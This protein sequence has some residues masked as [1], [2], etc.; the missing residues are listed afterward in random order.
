MKKLAFIALTAL[1]IVSC[2]D[3]NAEAMQAQQQKSIDSLKVV[4]EQ[5]KAEEAKQRT[6]DSMRTV[7]QSRTK[8]V[9]ANGS[10]G[11]TTTTTTERKGWSGAAKGAVIGAGAGAIGG[12]LIDKK[13]SGRGAIIGGLAGAGLG[14]GTGA[15][16]DSK[17]KK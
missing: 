5:Q 3:K 14:A 11:T 12:A 13:H 17:K 10:T 16:L 4:M 15:I 8:V 7:T 6:I 9:Y 2:K 1:T